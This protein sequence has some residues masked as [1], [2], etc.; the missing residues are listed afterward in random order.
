MEGSKPASYDEADD[1]ADG[2]PSRRRLRLDRTVQRSFAGTRKRSEYIMYSAASSI[3][4]MIVFR[5]TKALFS[6]LTFLDNH[7][8][9]S[10]RVTSLGVD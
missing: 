1:E 8:C 7:G 4:L 9:Y 10:S 5:E 2:R 3:K 6:S